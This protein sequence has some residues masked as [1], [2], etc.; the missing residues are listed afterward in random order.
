MD[1]NDVSIDVDVTVSTDRVS[2]ASQSEITFV[3]P[4]VILTNDHPSCPGENAETRD[5]IDLSQRNDAKKSVPSLFGNIE[6][7]ASTKQSD[8]S[9]N[10][11]NPKPADKVKSPK[12]SGGAHKPRSTTR[13]QSGLR[14]MQSVS[15][16]RD[17]RQPINTQASS[18]CANSDS[19]GNKATSTGDDTG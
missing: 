10:A 5:A 13:R 16:Q 4:N 19:G 1:T 3:Q 15:T 9:N 12:G 17:T 7:T 2:S 6:K 11:Q 8:S 14:R 18:A